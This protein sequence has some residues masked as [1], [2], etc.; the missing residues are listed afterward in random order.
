MKFMARSLASWHRLWSLT[1]M[2]TLRV[3]NIRSDWQHLCFGCHQIRHI[4]FAER[5]N[6]GLDEHFHV[7]HTGT[8]VLVR[9]HIY[10]RCVRIAAMKVPGFVYKS[11]E[12]ARCGNSLVNLQ[13]IQSVAHAQ[14]SL[15]RLKV[16]AALEWLVIPTARIHGLC[17]NRRIWSK[18]KI[19]RFCVS[20]IPAH[21]LRTIFA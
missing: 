4:L 8:G 2:A 1:T 18:A 11:N 15:H 3:W 7:E 6:V 9:H 20:A 17:D 16:F 13:R 21:E 14:F 12:A 10:F 19:T 5:I